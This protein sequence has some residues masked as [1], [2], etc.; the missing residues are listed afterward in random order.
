MKVQDVKKVVCVGGGTIGASWA[1][2]Y[3]WKGL[4]VYIQ[5]INEQALER[6]KKLINY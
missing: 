6:A 5:D 3:L 1:S 2:Y 4:N